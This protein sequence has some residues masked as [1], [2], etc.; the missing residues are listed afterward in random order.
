MLPPQVYSVSLVLIA[1]MVRACYELGICA[2]RML[3]SAE[4]M[5]IASLLTIVSMQVQ[6]LVC[7]VIVLKS[8]NFLA[9]TEE[10]T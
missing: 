9:L 2:C 8:E 7:R 4:L 10:G 3:G 1:Y 5:S 6:Y